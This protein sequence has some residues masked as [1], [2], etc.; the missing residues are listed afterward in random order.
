M[1][2]YDLLG[3]FLVMSALAA[4]PSASVA[5]VIVRSATVNVRNGIATAVGVVAG[6][7]I[8]ITMAMMGLVAL[9]EIMGAFFAMI[10][11]L[12]AGYLVWVG[13]QL[14][15]HAADTRV[16]DAGQV[17]GGMATSFLSGLALTLGD[18]KAILFYASL[19]PAF[20]DIASLTM[21]DVVLIMLVT[22]IAVGG[23]KVA[24]ALAANRIACLSKDVVFRQEARVAAGGLL[25]GAGGYLI[26]KA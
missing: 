10:R 6:D 15:R 23:V 17:K 7:L 8:F 3:L 19:F 2:A 20:V 13:W 1:T 26:V 12:A 16:M 22:V 14:I 5:L 25:V 9:S 24:Y 18:I 11:Y 4:I 21:S